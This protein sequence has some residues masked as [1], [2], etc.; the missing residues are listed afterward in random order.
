LAIASNHVSVE[1]NITLIWKKFGELTSTGTSVVG[2]H[3]A[4]LGD[5]KL[6]LIDTPGFDDTHRSDTDI[7]REIADWLNRSYKANIT[8]AGIVYLHRIVD[9]RIGGASMKNLRMFKKLCGQKGLSSVVLA[10]TMWNTVSPEEGARREHELVSNKEFWAEMVKYGSKV[11]RHDDGEAS[12]I[13][14][15]QYI[16]SQRRRM[17]LDIQEE[18]ASGKTLDETAAG[19]EVEAELMKMKLKHDKEMQELREEMREAKEANDERAQQ[20]I[21]AVR[22]ELEAKMAKEQEDRERMRVNIEQLQKER[23]EELRAE[24]EKIHEMEMERQRLTLSNE[25]A[26]SQLKIENDYRT[27]LLEAQLINERKDAEIARMQAEE[28]RRR[29]ECNVM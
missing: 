25:H 29:S 22:A 15:I 8:L 10:T 2:I 13:K 12:A 16:L 26:L 11:F 28:E 27:K 21:A 1:T 17:V 24:R 18:M 7:L 19:R 9:N 3:E 4:K 5:R 14:I 20:E 23:D 6:F